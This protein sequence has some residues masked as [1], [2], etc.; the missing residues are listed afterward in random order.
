MTDLTHEYKTTQ[1]TDDALSLVKRVRMTYYNRFMPDLEK[2]WQR[3]VDA[4]LATN[5]TYGGR[6]EHGYPIY[7]SPM[8]RARVTLADH[9][10]EPFAVKG[11]SYGVLGA[12]K[13]SWYRHALQKMV[14]DR[15]DVSG[16]EQP[17]ADE[18]EDLRA[19]LAE[20]TQAVCM[21]LR[22]QN[23]P[24]PALAAF[25]YRALAPDA[26]S[27]T[28]IQRLA[29]EHG[30]Q[31]AEMICANRGLGALKITRVMSDVILGATCLPLDQQ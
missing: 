13:G 22:V 2:E 17:F 10:D 7:R 25:H 21:Y 30:S 9:G 18:Q 19:M 24:S 1:P 31:V 16:L 23:P 20:D 27:R 5:V 4:L 28:E 26:P 14:D 12:K 3:L 6:L 8:M 11:M 29:D 15:S